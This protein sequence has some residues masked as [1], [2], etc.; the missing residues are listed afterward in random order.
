MLRQRC[1]TDDKNTC[2]DGAFASQSQ[3]A[4][5]LKDKTCSDKHAGAHGQGQTSVEVLTIHLHLKEI[6]CKKTLHQS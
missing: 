3:E 2:S 4:F 1:P 5:L 6:N